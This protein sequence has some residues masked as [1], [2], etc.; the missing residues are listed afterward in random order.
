MSSIDSASAAGQGQTQIQAAFVIA[1]KQ[2]DAL[3]AQGEAMVQLIDAAAA[4]GKS[5]HTGKNF[6]G[7]G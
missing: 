5:L 6:N 1:A 7:V 2:L 3:E 4:I